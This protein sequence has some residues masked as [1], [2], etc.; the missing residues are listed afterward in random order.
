ME[1]SKEKIEEH[2]IPTG[3]NNNEE[4]DEE[5]RPWQTSAHQRPSGENTIEEQDEESTTPLRRSS[6]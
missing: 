6:R 3:S 4:E 1:P 5:E 2:L